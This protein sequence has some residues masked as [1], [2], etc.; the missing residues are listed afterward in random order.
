MKPPIRILHLE[1]DP[2]DAALVQATLE[3]DGILCV[4]TCVHTR[5]AFVSALENGSVDLVLSDYSLPAFDGLSALAIASARWSEIPFILVSGTLGE[6][7][8]IDSLKRGAT[9]YVLKQRLSRL[10][11]AVRRAMQE[12]KERGKRRQAEAKRREYSRKL[13]VLSR[14]LVSAQ[15]TERRNI[16]RE[17]HDEIGQ[18]LTVMQLNLQA[19]LEARGSELLKTRLH[20]TLEVV[21]HLLEQVHNLAL[22]LRPTMLDD[23]GLEPALIWLTNR[24]SALAGLKGEVH[25]AILE[26]RLDPVIETECYRIVQEALT[27][28]MRHAQ[29]HAVTVELRAENG[30]L[31]LRVRDDG[32]G[33]DVATVRGKAV[34]GASLGLLSMEERAALAG[35][36]L[37]FS[38]A[39]AQGTEVHAWFPLKWQNSHT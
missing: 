12:V 38:A 11:P 22:N 5:S 2:N 35:G 7:R 23:L 28:V 32:I 17:L 16:A 29:A 1:D 26:Q 25:T 13:Q 31:H 39:P 37:E 10:A 6:E 19:M 36:G 24:Q 30:K 34:R 8:A 27:N 20:A 3:A 4:T 9:D 33:F 21:G 14:R 18:A 15:E